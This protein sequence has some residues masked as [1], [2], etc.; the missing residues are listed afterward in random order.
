MLHTP[1]YAFYHEQGKNYRSRTRPTYGLPA[2]VFPITVCL[3]YYLLFTKIR[4]RGGFTSLVYNVTFVQ[5]LA[6]RSVP[7]LFP[8]F[9]SI[10]EPLPPTQNQI[11]SSFRK[12][13]VLYAPFQMDLDQS[14]WSNR[15]YKSSNIVTS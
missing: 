8:P 9:C 1:P 5:N 15:N 10:R 13:F 11:Q 2:R 4:Y 14:Q 7:I 3:I 6:Q 12:V